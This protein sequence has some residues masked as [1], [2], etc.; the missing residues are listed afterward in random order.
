[1]DLVWPEG[2]EFDDRAVLLADSLA[3][4]EHELGEPVRLVRKDPGAGARWLCRVDAEHEGPAVL[5]RDGDLIESV[6]RTGAEM[7][8]TFSLRHTWLRT[9]KDT[10]AVDAANLDEVVERITE[11]IRF[12]YPAMALR[13]IDWDQ[14]CEHYAPKVLAAEDPFAVCQ[15]WVA[16]LG[17]AH[18]AVHASPRA[19]PLPYKANRTTFT[20]VPEGSAAWE[21]GVR[22]G[23]R[24][25]APDERDIARRTGASPH[26]LPFMIGRRLLSATESREW[27][28]FGPQDKHAEWTEQPTGLP[29]G[30]LVTWREDGYLR[31]KQWVPNAGIPEALDEV[32]TAKGNELTLDL[33]GN[34]GGNVVLATATRNRF[35]RKETVL[36]SVRYCIDGELTEHVP[37]VGTPSTGVRWDKKLTVL[38]DAMTYSASED[39]LLGLQGLEHVTVIG[40][41]SGGGSGRPRS[42]RLLPGWTLNVSTVLTYDRDG[43]CVEN[44][45]I[46][47]NVSRQWR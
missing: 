44:S 37:M 1:M 22:A 36:G 5:R 35:L 29:F 27:R 4:L 30:D 25:D 26:M 47:V 6:G 32:L 16:R 15:E 38:T 34:V 7:W 10:Y 11:E 2:A 9:G 21:A 39:F 17:D 3:T 46:P 8:E 42:V 43:H 13:G 12:S 31:I 20:D 14:L 18:T 33:R 23:W 40:E 41:P 24:L 45:G 19:L 28:A